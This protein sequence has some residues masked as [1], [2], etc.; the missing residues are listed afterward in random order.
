MRSLASRLVYGL[1][2]LIGLDVM[3]LV[4]K[5]LALNLPEG[6]AGRDFT[7]FPDV[8][9]RMLERGQL[10]RKARA[11]GGFGRVGKHADGSKYAETFDLASEQWREAVAPDLSDVRHGKPGEI[12]FDDSDC[13]RLAWQIFGGASTGCTDHS[14]CS[15]PLDPTG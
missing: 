13:G 3:D 10:G 8:E 5:N 9:Q 14:R 2:D 1:I 11:L 12:M 6:D 7:S 4:G 15:T